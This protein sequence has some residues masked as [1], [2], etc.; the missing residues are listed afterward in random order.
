M[1]VSGNIDKFDWPCL[2]RRRATA[3]TEI[4]HVLNNYSF[5]SGKRL[6]TYTHPMNL[7]W[8]FTFLFIDLNVITWSRT[9]NMAASFGED[10]VLWA[11]KGKTI[12]TYVMKGITCLAYNCKGN[13]IAVGIK[14]KDTAL[15]QIQLWDVSSDSVGVFLTSHK[16]QDSQDEVRCVVW[17]PKNEYIIR[18]AHEYR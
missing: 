13:Y 9:G 3:V 7:Q 2:P 1:V 8:E 6:H 17:D 18:W 5:Y 10:L 4:T 16:Y 12:L 15:P 14:L 11:P